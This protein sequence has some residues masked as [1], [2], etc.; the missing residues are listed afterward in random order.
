MP[1]VFQVEVLDIA[2][3]HDFYAQLMGT[4]YRKAC[5]VCFQVEALDIAWAHDIYAQ[6]NNTDTLVWFTSGPVTLVHRMCCKTIR[7]G[8]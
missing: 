5:R 4:D 8:L 3:P 2:W 1:H 6:L 7:K